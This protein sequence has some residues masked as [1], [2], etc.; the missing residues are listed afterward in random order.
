MIVEQALG[1]HFLMYSAGEIDSIL[2]SRE[3][4]SSGVLF[5][6]ISIDVQAIFEVQALA[7]KMPMQQWS[8]CV[9]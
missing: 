7:I 3:M 4:F 1:V 8:C 2:L 5:I 9:G 6:C